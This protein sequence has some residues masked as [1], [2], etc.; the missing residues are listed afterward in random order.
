MTGG[1]GGGGTGGSGSGGTSG[2]TATS[3][4]A[5]TG[6]SS[7]TGATAEITL[8]PIPV[9]IIEF[10][11]Q[12]FHDGSAIMMPEAPPAS[13]SSGG[14][15][16]ASGGSGSDTEEPLTGV[17]AIG[18]AFIFAG[19]YPERAM[20]ITG[21]T[22]SQSDVPE[23]FRISRERAGVIL[24]LLQGNAAQWV[25]TCA[26]RQTVQ[27]IKRILKYTQDYG[28]SW[29]TS[30]WNCD[31]GEIN[32]TWNDQTKTALNNFAR[33]FNADLANDEAGIASL[34]ENLGDIVNDADQN[35][36][37]QTHWRSIYHLYNRL[38]CDFLGKTPTELDA[39]RSSLRWVSNTVK[40]VGCGHSFP[41]PSG[42]RGD[43]KIRSSTDN[44]IELLI[45]QAN[46]AESDAPAVCPTLPTNAVHNLETECPL[47]HQ[48]H[49]TRNYVGPG[50]RYAVVYHLRFRYYNRIKKSFEDV[51]GR[52]N[53]KAY[54]RDEAAGSSPEEIPCIAQ[55]QEGI[56]TVRVRF[57]EQN[58]NFNNK[59][60]YFGFE[61]TNKVIHTTAAGATP[62]VVDR[63]DDFDTKSFAEK[64]QYYDL[65][66][67]WF[68]FNYFTRHESTPANDERFHTHIKDKR[69]IKPYGGNVTSRSEPLLFSLDD[70]VL[71]DNGTSNDQN[72][73]DAD[74]QNRPKNLCAGGADPGSRVKV[75]IADNTSH[76]LKLWQKPNDDHTSAPPPSGSGSGGSGSGS[77]SIAR[78]R[79]ERVRFE[80]NIV[81]G[82]APDAKVIHFREGFYIIGDQRTT[83]QPAN[84]MD[85]SH[86]PVVGARKAIRDDS[87]RHI[88]WPRKVDNNEFGYTGDYDMHYFHRLHLEGSHPVSYL[89]I[90]LSMNFMLDTRGA[91]PRSAWAGA[92]LP[93]GETNPDMNDVANFVNDGVYNAIARWNQKGFFYDET[94]AGNDTIRIYPMYFFDERETFEIPLAN[95][96][97]NIDFGESAQIP[98]VF[99]HAGYTAAE[100]RAFGGPVMWVAFLV[101]ES[102][103]S[104]AWSIRGGAIAH[105]LMR[106][107][108]STYQVTAAGWPYDS[109]GYTEN[110]DPYRC[111]VFAHELG[112]ATSL[113]DEYI[114]KAQINIGGAS[115]NHYSYS[116]HLMQ[117]GMD[118]NNEAVIMFHNG[119]P[120]LRHCWY[121]IHFIND[122][123]SNIPTGT[124]HMLKN[125]QF[126]LRFQRGTTDHSFRR[127]IGWNPAGT[128]SPAT[129]SASIKGDIRHAVIREEQYR[130]PN[131]VTVSAAPNLSTLDATLQAKVR[132]DAT[133]NFLFWTDANVISDADRDAL[134]NLFTSDA[135]KNAVNQLQ[136]KSLSLRRLRLELF[137]VGQDESSEGESSSKGTFTSNQNNYR[138]HGVLV[139]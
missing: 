72:I 55:Y 74:Q 131:W 22:A 56:H 25:T 89:I 19:L 2:S 62:R 84:W 9:D 16:G 3:A 116:Q 26:G 47:W 138:Y 10:E 77:S 123:I 20:L 99:S 23:S 60:L 27:D 113:Q 17:K 42:E 127:H 51:P 105:S 108:K 109:G 86:K 106:L 110:G 114:K 35:R 4:A 63:P 48:R 70:V 67:K 124:D 8:T 98:N 39:M 81:S 93:G 121:H 21:H 107:R 129:G 90:Y 50:D 57:G 29:K 122:L 104:W 52:L 94:T 14:S 43:D 75:F 139:V 5:S 37:A 44:R 103:G 128:A 28:A 33:G 83:D 32:N 80:R 34:P 45:Y 120:R 91:Q 97:N 78:P 46:Q 64:Y 69:Q 133:N 7:P 13:S 66:A 111:F 119:V 54:K 40:M 49:F 125:K 82:L 96:P 38:V 58:P 36:L 31:P 79:A 115:R 130:L 53:I 126:V 95:A 112:H 61:T 18:M 12:L 85:L 100:Q 117:Y 30:D 92:A 6:T 102:T 87:D 135:N 76:R 1:S 24:Y 137:D 41:V 136:L 88:S 118:P 73:Q 134:R 59:Y 65:P 132:F 71:M 68:S 15:G 11:D 101:P